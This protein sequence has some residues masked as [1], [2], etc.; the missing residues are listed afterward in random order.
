MGQNLA[1]PNFMLQHPRHA[2]RTSSSWC[3]G[4]ERDAHKEFLGPSGSISS[5]TIRVN[6]MEDE[7]RPLDAEA[8][9]AMVPPL[10]AL[11]AALG[12]KAAA[13]GVI[14]GS[15]NAF[16]AARR[17]TSKAESEARWQ[18]TKEAWEKQVM[19][20]LEKQQAAAQAEDPQADPEADERRAALAMIQEEVREDQERRAALAMFR[21]DADEAEKHQQ[22]LEDGVAALQLGDTSMLDKVAEEL[23]AHWKTLQEASKLEP[24]QEETRTEVDFEQTPRAPPSEEAE[25]EEKDEGA[26]GGFE[27][28]KASEDET[29]K[30]NRSPVGKEQSA[31]SGKSEP[32]VTSAE[33]VKAFLA[34]HGFREVNGKRRRRMRNIFPLHVAVELGDAKMVALLLEARADT[35]SRNSSGLTALE[36]AHRRGDA[37]CSNV[38]ETFKVG[39]GGVV[40]AGPSQGCG[41]PASPTAP[42]C[43]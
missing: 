29:D 39:H 17:A 32:S 35:S 15:R 43:E 41:P 28:A 31:S 37:E 42:V 14:G 19:E 13:N 11:R 2:K 40:E 6:L 21:R 9:T 7:A 8:S 20:S 5:E 4:R 1:G 16:D 26:A 34:Q 10:R 36:L 33:A 12:A 18:A 3:S 25:K 24:C 30:E 22:Q 27:S 38:F 23:E